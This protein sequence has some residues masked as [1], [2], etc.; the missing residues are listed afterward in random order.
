VDALLLS[1]TLLAWIVLAQSSKPESSRLSHEC[2][3]QSSSN[4]GPI[5]LGAPNISLKNVMWSTNGS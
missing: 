3:S 5:I 2:L 4:D 1:L